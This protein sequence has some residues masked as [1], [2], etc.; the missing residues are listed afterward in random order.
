[1]LDFLRVIY[2]GTIVDPMVAVSDRA[3]RDLSRTIR[4]GD[5]S[6]EKRNI[7]RGKVTKQFKEQIPALVEI[8]VKDQK[9]YD[10]WHYRICKQICTYYHDAGVTFYYGQAQ[11]WINMT[12]K[13]LYIIGEYTFDNLF[14][15]LHV[16]VDNYVFRIANKELGIPQPKVSWSRWDDYNKQYM[17]YQ[18]SS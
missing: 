4:F 6:Q 9:T 8:G 14:Q 5:M 16:P 2:F 10:V 1:M 13:Y 17:D 7:L 11:K 3:Y 15:Y 12:M 18:F